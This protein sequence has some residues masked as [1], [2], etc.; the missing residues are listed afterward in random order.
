MKKKNEKKKKLVCTKQ[1]S[2]ER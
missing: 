2:A 1:H